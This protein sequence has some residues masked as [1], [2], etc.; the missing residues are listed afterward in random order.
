MTRGG[1]LGTDT[2]DFV[3]RLAFTALLFCSGFAIAPHAVADDCSVTVLNKVGDVLTGSIILQTDDPDENGED[4]TA[5]LS[6]SGGELNQTVGSYVA[7]FPF[8][9]TATVSNETI[10]GTFPDG[11]GDETCSIINLSING[12][13][14]LT[15]QQ[16]LYIGKESGEHALASI[17]V[18]AVAY[19]CARNGATIGLCTIPLAKISAEMLFG[20]AVGLKYIIDP[21]DPNYTIIA[22]PVIPVIPPVSVASG[23]PPSLVDATNALQ[24]QEAHLA[25]VEVALATTLN[26]ISGAVA[27]NDQVWVQRQTAVAGSLEAQLA[28]LLAGEADALAAFGTALNAAGFAVDLSPDDVSAYEADVASNGLNADQIATLQLLGADDD[29]LTAATELTVVQDAGLATAFP[30]TLTDPTFLNLLRSA[31]RA[32]LPQHRRAVVH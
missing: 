16:K 8:Q 15:V 25:A 19:A 7:P 14:T 23:L 17:L 18:G 3:G 28:M 31:P 29:D 1:R 4:E 24:T 9:F 26:R 30:G 27:A 20:A 32:L 2:T 21:P 6:S 22:T 13:T 11:D 5:M 12:K 10:S